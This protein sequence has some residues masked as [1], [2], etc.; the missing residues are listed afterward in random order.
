MVLGYGDTAHE[1]GW[2]PPSP[3]SGTVISVH[4]SSIMP[5]SQT[6][7]SIPDSP[8]ESC[9]YPAALTAWQAV[10]PWDPAPAPVPHQH[11][12]ALRTAAQG[13]GAG[14][15]PSLQGKAQDTSAP[16][17]LPAHSMAPCTAESDAQAKQG[18]V[19]H[20]LCLAPGFIEP[21]KPYPAIKKQVLHKI[22]LLQ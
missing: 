20:S 19:R 2:S 18:R 12:P 11:R 9:G 7:T 6:P 17:P 22:P 3:C 8:V 4:V 14:M 10:P 15:V 1:Q 16:A 5:G 13:E 21:P